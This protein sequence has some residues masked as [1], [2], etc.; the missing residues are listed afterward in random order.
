MAS[1]AASSSAPHWPLFR[2][3]V[4]G[5]YI[6]QEIYKQILIR[7][8]VKRRRSTALGIV[9]SGGSVG[10]LIIPIM[11]QNLIPQIGSVTSDCPSR[12]FILK[13]LPPQISLDH[14]GVGSD[15]FVYNGHYEL[16]W[17]VTS[18][19]WTLD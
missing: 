17:F 2:I 12:S 15:A 14:A 19:G 7:N 18:A 11:V 9:A 8:P 1:P 16:G 4:S 13:S 5:R 6:I 3:G 10:G